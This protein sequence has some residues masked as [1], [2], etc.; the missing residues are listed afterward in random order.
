MGRM[1]ELSETLYLLLRATGVQGLQWIQQTLS[2]VPDFVATPGDV[3]L[4]AHEAQLASQQQSNEDAFV[5]A[6][7]ELGELCR[8]NRK[9]FQTI[10]SIFLSGALKPAG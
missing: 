6:A 1:D 9:C 8:R 5:G 7:C 2:R 3:Q 10:T 4:F